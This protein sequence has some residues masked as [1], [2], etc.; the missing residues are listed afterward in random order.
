MSQSS[1]SGFGLIKDSTPTKFS[2]N[3]GFGRIAASAVQAPVRQ[4]SDIISALEPGADGVLP[5]F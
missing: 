2:S 3:T 1:D 5:R 4:M